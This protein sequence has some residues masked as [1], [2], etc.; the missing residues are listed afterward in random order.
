MSLAAMA[1]MLL[2][3]KASLGLVCCAMD[4]PECRVSEPPVP[5]IAAF[6]LISPPAVKLAVLNEPSVMAV[7]SATSVP[8]VSVS[9]LDGPSVKP[10]LR[11]MLC[12]A[13]SVRPLEEPSESAA[14]TLMSLLAVSV[15]LRLFGTAN[16]LRTEIFP[17]SLPLILAVLTVTLL[18]ASALVSVPVNNSEFDKLPDSAKSGPPSKL[19]LPSEPGKPETPLSSAI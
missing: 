14:L 1:L 4:P 18:L 5:V 12:A 11:P 9:A 17:L 19:A 10:A 3:V 16:A 7:L 13:V 15:R 8:A 6:R 2:M